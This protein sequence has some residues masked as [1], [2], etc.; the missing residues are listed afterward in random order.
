[1]NTIEFPNENKR[2]VLLTILCIL[3]FVHS[4]YVI[5]SEMPRLINPLQKEDFERIYEL[6][7]N[8]EN[9]PAFFSKA[10]GQFDVFV[11]NAINN[12]SNIA[13]STLVLYIISFSGVILMWNMKKVGFHFYTAAQILLLIIPFIFLGL[14]IFTL[15]SFIFSAFFTVLFIVLYALNLNKME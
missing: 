1:M 15:L 6:L 8:I 4:I 14:N 5:L 9:P 3:S 13:L 11:E 7:F 10:I 12:S 2:P